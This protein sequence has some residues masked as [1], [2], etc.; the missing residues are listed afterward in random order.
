MTTAINSAVEKGDAAIGAHLV[1]DVS[2][3][4]LVLHQQRHAAPRFACHQGRA[5]GRVATANHQ[6]I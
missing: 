4:A 1:R 2:L 5:Q 6:N 3:P